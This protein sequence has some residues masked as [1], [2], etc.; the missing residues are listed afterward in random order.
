MQHR[1]VPNSHCSGGRD[2]LRFV[3]FVGFVGGA[4]AV[5]LAESVVD[6]GGGDCRAIKVH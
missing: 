2:H 3:G 1:A 4:R 5:G 6:S